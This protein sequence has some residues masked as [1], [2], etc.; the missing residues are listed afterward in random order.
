MPVPYTHSIAVAFLTTSRCLRLVFC[1]IFCLIFCIS[2]LQAA[3]QILEFAGYVEDPVTGP[4]NQRVIMRIEI[5]KIINDD[6]NLALELRE[7]IPWTRTYDQGIEVHNG[8]FQIYLDLDDKGEPIDGNVFESSMELNFDSVDSSKSFSPEGK[9]RIRLWMRRSEFDDFER[10]LPD[11]PIDGFPGSMSSVGLTQF[12]KKIGSLTL[13]ADKS[14]TSEAVITV[15]DRRGRTQVGDG[16]LSLLDSSYNDSNARGEHGVY[17]EN[18]TLRIA[19]LSP[20]PFSISGA[21]VLMDSDLEMQGDLY[22]QEGDIFVNSLCMYKSCAINSDG[23]IFKDITAFHSVAFNEFEDSDDPEGSLGVFRLNPSGQTTFRDLTILN[24]DPASIPLSLSLTGGSHLKLS[25][26]AILSLKTQQAK[27]KAELSLHRG[28]LNIIPEF[29]P[30]SGFLSHNS[31]ARNLDL[32]LFRLGN[33]ESLPIDV[34]DEYKDPKFFKISAGA[35]FKRKGADFFDDLYESAII[36][37]QPRDDEYLLKPSRNSKL[38]AL[39]FHFENKMEAETRI[40]KRVEKN[41]FPNSPNRAANRKVSALFD[42]ILTETILKMLLGGGVINIHNHDLVSQASADEILQIINDPKFTDSARI[43]YEHIDPNLARMPEF[44]IWDKQNIFNAEARVLDSSFLIKKNLITSFG[45]TGDDA[46]NFLDRNRVKVSFG[47]DENHKFAYLGTLAAASS[48][49]TRMQLKNPLGLLDLNAESLVVHGSIDI[50]A[51]TTSTSAVLEI[52]GE[53]KAGGDLTVEGDFISEGNLILGCFQSPEFCPVPPLVQGENLLN[54]NQLAAHR[55]LDRNHSSYYLDPS[56]ETRLNTLTVMGDFQFESH[57]TVFE[58]SLRVS[59]SLTAINAIVGTTAAGDLG[60]VEARVFNSKSKDFYTD[61]SETSVW[62]SLDLE[63]SLDVKGEFEVG[64]NINIVGTLSAVSA[65]ISKDTTILGNVTVSKF[66]DLDSDDGTGTLTLVIDPAG[67]SKI[68]DVGV[69]LDTTVSGNILVGSNLTQGTTLTLYGNLLHTS[70]LTASKM[71][72]NDNS[73]YV[74]DPD[75]SSLLDSLEISNKA[76]VEVL[77]GTNLNVEKTLE[78]QKSGNFDGNLVVGGE[79]T[80]KSSIQLKN[81]TGTIVFRVDPDGLITA[82]SV[83]FTDF[84][85]ITAF[86]DLAGLLKVLGD[87]NIF[88]PSDYFELQIRVEDRFSIVD[89]ADNTLLSI[90]SQGNLNSEAG[91][92]FS[93]GD[94]RFLSSTARAVL[95]KEN[96]VLGVESPKIDTLVFQKNNGELLDLKAANIS[97][98]SSSPASLDFEITGF[99][100]TSVLKDS[101]STSFMAILSKTSIL[102]SVRVASISPVTLT[103]IPVRTPLFSDLDDPNYKIDLSSRTRLKDLTVNNLGFFRKELRIQPAT[104]GAGSYPTRL[105]FRTDLTTETASV[106]KINNTL[107]LSRLGVLSTSLDFHHKGGMT[108]HDSVLR[109]GSGTSATSISRL[110]MATLI[111]L[112]SFSFD[113]TLQASYPAYFADHLHSHDFVAGIDGD[114]IAKKDADNI[115]TGQN[116]FAANEDAVTLAPTSSSAAQWVSTATVDLQRFF[117][118]AFEISTTAF[119]SSHPAGS[120]ILAGGFQNA[121]L[122]G[123]QSSIKEFSPTTLNFFELTQN[124]SLSNSFAG[125]HQHRV[126][127]ELTVAGGI[128]SSGILQASLSKFNGAWTQSTIPK[129][130]A[131]SQSLGFDDD[132]YLFGGFLKENGKIYPSDRS[133]SGPAGTL[134]EYSSSS[135]LPSVKQQTEK[136]LVY[137]RGTT[138][139]RNNLAHNRERQ[140]FNHGSNILA[141]QISTLG[142]D[143]CFHDSG[144][145]LHVFNLVTEKNLNLGITGHDCQWGQGAE[146]D[147]IYYLSGTETYGTLARIARDGGSQQTFTGISQYELKDFHL[148]S[149][150]KLLMVGRTTLVDA[151]GEALLMRESTGDIKKIDSDG[152]D[153]AQILAASSGASQHRIWHDQLY[154]NSGTLA[155]NSKTQIFSSNIDGLDPRQ[156][157]AFPQGINERAVILDSQEAIVAVSAFHQESNKLPLEHKQACSATYNQRV[158]LFGSGPSENQIQEYNPQRDRFNTLSEALPFS[159]PFSCTYDQSSKVYFQSGDSFWYFDL[160]QTRFWPLSQ[161]S[162]ANN[163]ALGALAYSSQNQSVFFLEEVTAANS[164]FL[165]YAILTD[166][167]ATKTGPGSNYKGASMIGVSSGVYLFGN[168]NGV[169]NKRYDL[170]GNSWSSIQAFPGGSGSPMATLSSPTLLSISPMEILV[171]GGA[172]TSG[173]SADTWSYRIDSDTFTTLPSLRTPFNQGGVYL[174]TQSLSLF[175]GASDVKQLQIYPLNATSDSDFLQLYRLNLASLDSTWESSATRFAF[176]KESPDQD[177]IAYS[178]SDQGLSLYDLKTKSHSSVLPSTASSPVT[179][180]DIAGDENLIVFSRLESGSEVI[181]QITTTGGS[182]TNLSQ[183]LLSGSTGTVQ[184]L[185]PDH[186]RLYFLD[187]GIPKKANL[188]NALE[189]TTIGLDSGVSEM[190]YYSPAEVQEKR[191][192][193]LFTT[194]AT[195]LNSG[196]I[197]VEIEEFRDADTLAGAGEPTEKTLRI[198]E[199]FKDSDGNLLLSANTHRSTTNLYRVE[200][201]KIRPQQLTNYIDPNIFP[202]SAFVSELDGNTYFT[203]Q[204]SGVASLMRL[205]L[206]TETDLNLG[207]AQDLVSKNLFESRVFRNRSFLYENRFYTLLGSEIYRTQILS[208]T[209]GALSWSLHHR[210]PEVDTQGWQ[211]TQFHNRIYFFKEATQEIYEYFPVDKALNFFSTAQTSTSSGVLAVAQDPTTQSQAPAFYVVGN[212]SVQQLNILTSGEALISFEVRSSPESSLDQASVKLLSLDPTGHLF[213]RQLHGAADFTD[214]TIKGGPGNLGILD[215]SI[216]GADLEASSLTTNYIRD[217]SFY[218][219]HFTSQAIETIHINGDSLHGFVFAS[220]VIDNLKLGSAQLEARHLALSALKSEKLSDQ[221]FTNV[222]FANLSIGAEHLLSFSIDGS[223]IRSAS[224][225]AANFEDD[226]LVKEDFRAASLGSKQIIDGTIQDIDIASTTMIERHFQ[227]GSVTTNEIQNQSIT[228]ATIA[229]NTLTTQKIQDHSIETEDLADLTI[230]ASRFETGAVASENVINDSSGISSANL[231]DNALTYEKFAVDSIASEQIDTHAIQS[232]DL[233][234]QTITQRELGPGSIDTSKVEDN[235][236]INDLLSPTAITIDKIAPDAFA[237]IDF[238]NGSIIDRHIHAGT[239]GGLTSFG[240]FSFGNR[241]NAPMGVFENSIYLAGGLKLKLSTKTQE[242]VTGLQSYPMSASAYASNAT[243]LYLF[244]N[245]TLNAFDFNSETLNLLS[246]ATFAGSND[247][248]AGGLIHNNAFYFIGGYNTHSSKVHSFDFGTKTWTTRTDL[249][250]TVTGSES[251]SYSGSLWVFGNDTLYKSSDAGG[252]WSSQVLGVNFDFTGSDIEAY[253]AQF[254]IFGGSGDHNAIHRFDPVS[255]AITQLRSQD[256]D[257][258]SA[259]GGTYQV[260]LSQH[261]FYIPAYFGTYVGQLLLWHPQLDAA[262]ENRHLDDSSVLS[263]NIKPQSLTAINFAKDAVESPEVLDGSIQNNHIEFN[264]LSTYSIAETIFESAHFQDDSITSTKLAP[265]S[266]DS[267][268]ILDRSLVDSD[269]ADASIDSDALASDSVGSEE[270]QPLAITN[271]KIAASQLTLS[272]LAPDSVKGEDFTNGAIETQDIDDLSITNHVIQTQKILSSHLAQGEIKSRHLVNQS[273]IRSHILTRSLADRAFSVAAFNAETMLRNANILAHHFSEKSITLSKFSTLVS[274]LLTNSKFQSASVTSTDI[275][276]NMIREALIANAEIEEFLIEP[277]V[278]EDRSFATGAIRTH[279]LIF[280]SLQ[281]RHFKTKTLSTTDFLPSS[282]IAQQFATD[283]LRSEHFIDASLHSEDFKDHSIGGIIPPNSINSAQILEQ[284]LKSQDFA[285]NAVTTQALAFASVTGEKVRTG[286]DAILNNKVADLQITRLKIRPKS[287]LSIDLAAS[288]L[289]KEKIL[290]GTLSGAHLKTNNVDGSRLLDGSVSGS[291]FFTQTIASDKILG[292]SIDST[293]IASYQIQTSQILDSSILSAHIAPAAISK[294]KLAEIDVFSG[295]EILDGSIRGESIVSFSLEHAQIATDS[296]RF[297]LIKNNAIQAWRSVNLVGATHDATTATVSQAIVDIHPLIQGDSKRG[298]YVAIQGQDQLN[299]TQDFQSFTVLGGTACPGSSVTALYFFNALEGYSSCAN[300]NLVFTEDSGAA[301][302]VVTRVAE[303]VFDLHFFN[304]REALLFTTNAGSESIWHSSNSG[305]DWTRKIGPYSNLLPW[306]IVGNTVAVGRVIATSY[307]EIFASTNRGTSFNQQ[308][309]NN[310]I[311][312]SSELLGLTLVNEGSDLWGTL[313]KDGVIHLVKFNSF[314]VTH[315]EKTP[316]TLQAAFQNSQPLIQPLFVHNRLYFFTQNSS[317]GVWEFDLDSESMFQITPSLSL[318]ANWDEPVNGV[319]P[320]PVYLGDL[321]TLYLGNGGGTRTWEINQFSHIEP[322]TLTGASLASGA[323]STDHFIENSIQGGK[324]ANQALS[325]SHLRVNGFTQGQYLVKQLNAQTQKNL[326]AYDRGRKALATN[327]SSILRSLDAGESFATVLTT[328][329]TP[330]RIHGRGSVFLIGTSGAKLILTTDDSTSFTT[331][332]STPFSSNAF[333]GFVFD[334]QH[335]IALGLDA[336]QKLISASYDSDLGNFN[337]IKDNSNQTVAITTG[338]SGLHPHDLEFIDGQTGYLTVSRD[339]SGAYLF[340]TSDAGHSW[341]SLATD[342]LTGRPTLQVLGE[343]EFWLGFQDKLMK[344][345]NDAITLTQTPSSGEVL[346]DL[347]FINSSIGFVL[348]T[349]GLYWTD[350]GATNFTKLSNLA[351]IPDELVRVE[352]DK[353]LFAGA[354]LSTHSIFPQYTHQPIASLNKSSFSTA[355]PLGTENFQTNTLSGNHLVDNAL[356]TSKVAKDSIHGAKLENLSISNVHLIDGSLDRNLFAYD[357]I[358]ASKLSSNGIHG[359]DFK[360]GILTSDRI[361]NGSLTSLE[362]ADGVVS[363]DAIGPDSIETQHIQVDSFFGTVLASSQ[364]LSQH[365]RDET[366]TE[367]E[368]SS[369]SFSDDHFEDDSV[370]AIHLKTPSFNLTQNKLAK[371]RLTSASIGV[372]QISSRVIQDGSIFG[373]LIASQTLDQSKMSGAVI[374]EE[375]WQDDSILGSLLHS[376]I[377]SSG[378]IMDR[379]IQGSHFVTRT[380]SRQK[381]STTSIPRANLVSYSFTFREIG[382]ASV[383]AG[384]LSTAP[385]KRL[386]A[387]QIA[388]DAITQ[389]T[390]SGSFPENKFGDD[391]LV[392]SKFSGRV[393]TES[394]MQTAILTQGHFIDQGILGEDFADDTVTEAKLSLSDAF[395]PRLATAAIRSEHIATHSLSSDNLA[396]GIPQSKLSPGTIFSSQIATLLATQISDHSITSRVFQKNSLLD[397]ALAAGALQDEHFKD[398]SIRSAKIAD[399]FVVLSNLQSGIITSNHIQDLTLINDDFLG[400]IPGSKLESGTLTGGE[401]VAEFLYGSAIVSGSLSGGKIASNT[402]GSREMV[403]SGITPGLIAGSSLQASVFANNTL[404]ASDL[405]DHAITS[406]QLVDQSIDNTLIAT[407]T[408]PGDL[409]EN[410]AISGDHFQDQTILSNAIAGYG[411]VLDGIGGIPGN[412]LTNS[413]ITTAKL[414]TTDKIPAL[415]FNLHSV[416]ATSIATD[417]VRGAHLILEAISGNLFVNGID[418]DRIATNVLD[419]SHL[420]TPAFIS[421]SI[422]DGSI[423]SLSLKDNTLLDRN[424]ASA[425]IEGVDIND[426]SIP[427][428]KLASGAITAEIIANNSIETSDFRDGSIE[429]SQ[430]QSA[431]L[432]ASVLNFGNLTSSN[433]VDGSLGWESLEDAAIT[434]HHIPN[435]Y[436]S[437]AHLANSTVNLAWVTTGIDSNH[438]ADGSLDGSHFSTAIPGDR[439][440][441][442]SITSGKLA[443]VEIAASKFANSIPR[444]RIK[445]EDMVIEDFDTGSTLFTASSTSYRVATDSVLGS[446]FV[447]SSISGDRIKNRSVTSA[448]ITSALT[449]GVIPS[450]VV[451][452]GKIAD[453]AVNQAAVYANSSNLSDN[454]LLAASNFGSATVSSANIEDGSLTKTMLDSSESR[455][456][457]LMDMG[458][459][460]NETHAQ[461]LHFHKRTGIVCPTNYTDLGGKLEYC[462]SSIDISNTPENSVEVCANNAGVQGHVCSFQ[463]YNSACNADA[464]SLNLNTANNYITSNYSVSK[465]MGFQPPS[466]GCNLRTNPRF[467]SYNAADSDSFRCCLNN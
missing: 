74:V 219:H 32:S 38:R 263:K 70:D 307:G 284:G 132:L 221:G 424:F 5:I 8:Q 295:N 131:Y 167:W 42:P 253:E 267:R 308:S 292:S 379:E 394:K 186:E 345:V 390:L 330:Q 223:E 46:L 224:L 250:A 273:I 458:A 115:F 453:G 441:D 20:K 251:L 338:G 105:E 407:A 376:R 117:P 112:P 123:P 327:G 214:N 369:G 198:E 159:P 138:L 24:H 44:N 76:S 402:L 314:G 97:S 302:V 81:A 260:V 158:Y 220:A 14:E 145:A 285:D 187:S 157:T 181:Q 241:I 404:T 206:T 411:D 309:L 101:D 109:L 23:V 461:F 367:A 243:T 128:D 371:H 61:P 249:P 358:T 57:D 401:F 183:T 54:V 288:S 351:Q 413:A 377:L 59:K 368:F 153:T 160:N 86:V 104:S 336:N 361:L 164:S 119:S 279:H 143:L 163:N 11:F 48:D 335:M 457:K 385:S 136:A 91:S 18:A 26:H 415:K 428:S 254:Y 178:G 366:L 443:N 216:T 208:S 362:L 393:F 133:F 436:I 34:F 444:N 161:I 392:T 320:A 116:R 245:S 332:S 380:L 359:Q 213:A 425:S 296:I 329:E 248:G 462:I 19:T 334:E 182:L 36:N 365:L 27:A 293:S 194:V 435:G 204:S 258:G 203:K 280:A 90:D 304:R 227:T 7:E 266:V 68:I 360:K 75:G 268:V 423:T 439:F 40:N 432:E 85:K 30:S 276:T 299:S 127:Q 346:Q 225:I 463:E 170:G 252:S 231:S 410:K 235:S 120:F 450:G 177:Y 262:I 408:I 317:F 184:F 319:L 56:D 318:D 418:G 146:S 155:H 264:I 102:N 315:T 405:A 9:Y 303:P 35:F 199:V 389:A 354:S 126:N 271:A 290:S 244:R 426:G 300:Q 55:F 324:I 466:A 100:E 149:N 31:L 414:S 387:S 151:K 29:D 103:S 416:L 381:F 190:N 297:D 162:T 465:I 39:Q 396:A 179:G 275:A 434:S 51:P 139:F 313:K 222:D 43:E 140:I 333:L 242:T 350:D 233:A 412:R 446:D 357:S 433:V 89:A 246:T 421:S 417:A 215:G 188:N 108:L 353:L 272:L 94:L 152:T 341:S 175:G 202:A 400:F 328:G 122:S 348:T 82:R 37:L 322:G 323:I 238:E 382:N 12:Q 154:F 79:T 321:K 169:A 388:T 282:L 339:N 17:L 84:V 349:S 129:P 294:L 144:H 212:G 370:G 52:W 45:P 150:Q 257:I 41:R 437:T 398:E 93:T 49:I 340:K 176:A 205:D 420:T 422:K 193:L 83:E 2:P 73:N 53:L 312:T 15:G 373:Y 130:L 459:V 50:V 419:A 375:K 185:S 78:L 372:G 364:I 33:N 232:Q 270:V 121:D 395:A 148:H 440:Q 99:V 286:A 80:V 403:D 6:E 28:S 427:L 67:L 107:S 301:W 406:S 236:L 96:W 211:I 71:I 113:P 261:R 391:A 197:N 464:G 118:F 171:F 363:S 460:D 62:N 255:S 445:N 306:S 331:I 16:E 47:G 356:D 325:G 124:S 1:L 196:I 210:L 180:L 342:A 168:E 228:N 191:D 247:T 277:A 92:L 195:S 240:G 166:S 352:K 454:R 141:P 60:V 209:P 305:K 239:Q 291:L 447:D 63:G 13:R 397:A 22:L 399:D 274:N 383:I 229:N 281:D 98:E 449:S 311:T 172:N 77:T 217:N 165:E 337:A 192:G 289:R 452:S 4:Y 135:P 87:V 58:K 114:V 234:L 409:V 106:L 310:G 269:F 66:L 207:T 298:F 283:A 111:L 386:S 467:F 25:G 455:F 3:S 451:T 343:G 65:Q 430:V 347:H 316:A 147:L 442:G 125:I 72:D 64:G 173:V 110:T 10:I 237:T 201:G 448:H 200:A 226:S 355:E 156:I 142:I 287:L 429:G 431:T 378:Q 256:F 438:I 374:S 259:D 69:E 344:Y 230:Y 278:L 137:A 456:Q 95:K 218:G 21:M 134:L 174:E 189:P 265:G 326:Y 88:S 384:K